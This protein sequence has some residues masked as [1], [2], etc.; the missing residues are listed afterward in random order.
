VQELAPGLFTWT[1]LHP[2]WTPASGGPDGWEQEVRCY[3]LDAGEVLV[4]IDP[5]DPPAELRDAG[6]DSVV[7]LTVWA[8]ERSAAELGA[9]VLVPAASVERIETAAQPYEAG[10]TL[11][12]GIEAKPTP[13]PDEA[14]L[15]LPGHRALVSGDLLLGSPPRI[16]PESWLSHGNRVTVAEALRPL[17]DLPI[18]RFLPTHGDPVLA[19]A[20]AA[21]AEAFGQSD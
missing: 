19:D 18:E 1:A 3:A 5:L 12:G 21:L 20:R 14:L 16:C 2:E 6:K 9:P 13:Y 8:H 10:A 11:P 7:V 4:L 17:L 15:W